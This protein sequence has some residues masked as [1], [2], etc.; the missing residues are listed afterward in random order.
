[1][2]HLCCPACEWWEPI[3]HYRAVGRC[4]RRAPQAQL[5]MF[6]EYQTLLGVLAEAVITKFPGL[7]ISGEAGEAV[8]DAHIMQAYAL[9]PETDETDFCG[10]FQ[11]K[12][13]D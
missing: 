13:D 2:S 5:G 6:R 11:E 7:D 9:W 12:Q 3:G 10:D 1:M 8:A 4:H